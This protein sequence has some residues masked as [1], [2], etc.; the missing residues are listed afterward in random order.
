MASSLV[1]VG[2]LLLWEGLVWVWVWVVGPW[3][4]SASKAA[5]SSSSTGTAGAAAVVVVVAGVG[6]VFGLV[7][8]ME[9]CCEAVAS[10]GINGDR[11]TGAALGVVA[12]G[13]PVPP[14][15]GVAGRD[16]ICISTPAVGVPDVRRV[17][18]GVMGL[19]PSSF[20][21]GVLVSGWGCS[22]GDP[23]GFVR[24]L[25]VIVSSASGMSSSESA[26]LRLLVGPV[27]SER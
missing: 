13:V 17:S 21:A 10:S 27:A 18:G 24:F 15:P 3:T 22:V 16:G 4:R 23:S 26:S 25:L 19:L 1:V 6:W 8:R 11:P 7:P 12:L 14:G 20:F 2:G 5:H 9:S